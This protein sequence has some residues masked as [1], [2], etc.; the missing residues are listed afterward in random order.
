MLNS[1]AAL[2]VE[3]IDNIAQYTDHSGLLA[4]C[5]THRVLHGV[6]LRR[7][8]H[9]VA[10]EN[11]VEAVR[12]FRTLSSS[13]D[14]AHAVRRLRIRFSAEKMLKAFARIFKA[15]LHNLDSIESIDL[16]ACPELFGL[17][18]DIH[19]P[20]LRTCCIPFS[21]DLITFL[22]LHPTLSGLSID[23]VPHGSVSSWSS[24]EAINMTE[25]QA[26]CGPELVALS[27][28]PQ[29]RSTSVAIF[30]HPGHERSFPEFFDAITS[31]PRA[32]LSYL[33]NIILTWE[34]T[35]LT[36]IIN[37]IPSLT[38]LTVRNVSSV[39]MPRD[40]EAFFAAAEVVIG[41]LRSLKSLSIVQ[42]A[43]PR[44]FDPDDLHWE[45]ET[46][47]RWGDMSPALHLCRLPS[48]TTW[49]RIRADSNV[50]Y[51][52]NSADGDGEV[53]GRFRWFLTTVITSTTLPPEYFAMLEVIAGKEMVAALKSSFEKEGVIPEFALAEKPAGISVTFGVT[54]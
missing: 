25:L 15:G 31:N 27:V 49:I 42:K 30:W 32:E 37:R 54:V 39:H 13:T 19:L 35:L 26:F 4:L 38:S 23:P 45:F 3:L 10:L 40:L 44:V 5:L 47:R 33:D 36:A 14:C 46:V 16:F 24:M 34:P 1:L 12:C 21:S 6:C 52:T 18:V 11:S 50:W 9:T 28:I 48:E 20:R 53:L 2:P 17:M 51:P 8:Y 7:I 29:S 22:Q 41:S 43:L